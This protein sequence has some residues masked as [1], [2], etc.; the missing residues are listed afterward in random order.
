[1]TKLSVNLNKVALLRN[2]RTHGMPSVIHAAEQCI[3]AGAQGITVH[4]RP[5]RRHIRPLDVYE[6]SNLLKRF[7][8]IEFNIEGN[9]FPEFL[10]IVRAVRPTQCTLVP[11]D[12]SAFTSDHGWNLRADAERLGPLIQEMRMWGS[13]ISLFMDADSDEWQV[14][15]EIGAGPKLLAF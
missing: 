11:D 15:K 1:M 5:D 12:P 14:A 9:P 13:R 10:E 6:L 3:A 8:G 2:T 4:P 7:P